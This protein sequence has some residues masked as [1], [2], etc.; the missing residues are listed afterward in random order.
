MDMFDMGPDF[1]TIHGNCFAT[2]IVIMQSWYA[3]LFL[4]KERS[5]ATVK[6]ILELGFARQESDQPFSEVMELENTVMRTL[7]SGS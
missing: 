7:K 5:A 6:E 3:M 2:M 4:H 1:T